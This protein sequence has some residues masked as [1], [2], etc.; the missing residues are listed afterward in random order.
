M[1]PESV[2]SPSF[3]ELITRSGLPRLEARILLELAS[4]RGRSWLIGHGEEAASA[5]SV[6]RFQALVARRL[7]GEPVAYLTGRREF[8]GLDL[9]VA[10]GVLIPR[11]ETELL[12]D[13]AI[14]II[15]RDNDHATRPRSLLDLG[16]GS[17]AIALAIC[18][19]QPQ[20]RIVATDRSEEALA[21]AR[22][23]AARLEHGRHISF[24]LG[25]W[26]QAIGEDERFDVIVSNPPYIAEG[27]PHLLAA[28]LRHEPVDALV[29]GPDGLAAIRAIVAGAPHH[30]Q[31]SGWLLIEH[32]YDQ[33]EAV[34]KIFAQAR[35]SSIRTL[36]DLEGRDRVTEGRRRGRNLEGGQQFMV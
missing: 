18:A 28:D 5:D 21:Q 24:R 35:F 29:S 34:R 15:V 14:E 11:P 32:G 23:N 36:L 22:L 26:W 17:G 9:A 1:T 16:T 19:H 10:P 20:T 2:P 7:A 3:D 33:G 4:G 12:V 27:D 30:L 6:A 25:S 8:H 13:R 31:G